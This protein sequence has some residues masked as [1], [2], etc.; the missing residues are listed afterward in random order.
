MIATHLASLGVAAYPRAVEVLRRRGGLAIAPSRRQAIEGAIARVMTRV[1]ILD[2]ERFAAA[3][4]EGGPIFDEVMAVVT[5]GETY[6]FR[7]PAQFAFLRE[8]VF[9][10]IRARQ[11]GRT[12]R[13]WS[14]ACAT[15]EEPYS[16]AI[17]AMES[18]LTEPTVIGT[19]VSRTRLAAARRGHYRAWSMRGVPRT[20]VDRYFAAT[21]DEYIIAADYR[22]LVRFA[23]LNLA[24]DEYPSAESGVWG[25]DVVLCRNV[26]IYF[27]AESTKEVAARLLHSLSPEGYLVLGASDPPLADIV[28]CDVV[29]TPGGVAYRRPTEAGRRRRFV[30]PAAATGPSSWIA[31]PPSL[32]AM[33]PPVHVLEA[34]P[35]VPA[36]A[37]EAPA[38]PTIDALR[39]AYRRRDYAGAARIGREMFEGD[40]DDTEAMSLTVR[41]LAN[42]GD[43]REAEQLCVAMLDQRGDV[44]ELRYLLATLMIQAGQFQA[45]VTEARR[46]LY[47][48][49]AHGAAYLALAD[50]QAKLGERDAARATL[51]RAER[52]LRASVNSTV[53]R[54]LDEE[55]PTRLLAIASARLRSLQAEVV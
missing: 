55:S 28:E 3:L 40:V 22:R 54:D 24:G 43:L 34:P 31:N 17:A 42:T 51:G 29:Q 38:A 46:A 30:A 48:D 45:A 7:E 15:G 36:P 49:R 50:A 21:D 9:P 14:A 19:D 27:D 13:L 8:V 26:L 23:Y 16:L 33:A 10:E 32:V 25:F 12:A 47:I 53:D 5:V 1:G 6:F 41:A 20:V 18:G 35:P 2:P 39:T 44:A 4:A 52:A 37:V 11:P